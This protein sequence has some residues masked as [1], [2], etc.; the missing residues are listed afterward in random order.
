MKKCNT[1]VKI[2]SSLIVLWTANVFLMSLPYKFSWAPETQYIFG[3][4]WDWLWGVFTPAIWEGFWAYGAYIIGSGELIVSIMLLIPVFFYIIKMFWGLK[5]K[6]TP[7]HL[8]A[9]WGLWMIALMWWAVFFHLFTPL[10]TVVNG[11]GS[12]LFRAAVSIL[13]SGFILFF[14][15]LK[16]L[17]AK[18][19]KKSI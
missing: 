3:T 12:S 2:I 8:L 10:W 7:E 17:K 9:L 13:V 4:I 11:D 19:C 18:Y 15:H 1:G 16:A 6:S 5:S 14:F